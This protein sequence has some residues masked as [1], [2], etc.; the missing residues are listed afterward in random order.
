[1]NRLKRIYLVLIGFLLVILSPQPLKA[2]NG[3]SFT[4]DKGTNISHWLS[5]SQRRGAERSAF[6]TEKDVRYLAGL[7]FD[8]I[9]I[10]VDEEQLWTEDGKKVREAFALLH[11][12][13][14]W[15][16]RAGLNVIVDL[17]ILRSHHFNEGERPLWVDPQ[18]QE[19]FLQC[20]KD[21]S[22]ELKKYPNAL[23]AYELM[24]EPVADDPEDW[25]KL[26][27]KGVEVIRKNE[28]Q[29]TI[30]IGSN[31]WNKPQTFVDLRVPEDDPNFIL[32]FHMYEPMLI[33]HY[34]A[35]W[36][37]TRDFEGEVNYP[38]TIVSED[39]R[40]KL[41]GE[42]AQLVREQ[43]LFYD[44]V[45]IEHHF[46]KAIARAQELN[47]PLHCGEWGVYPTVSD[48]IRFAWYKD[49]L[50]VLHKYDIAWSTWDYKGGFGI[51]RGGEEDKELI[52]ILVG[53]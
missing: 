22:E 28:P 15:S 39:E 41:S 47:L 31:L 21:L 14:Q 3:P 34:K 33:T 10:P 37:K 26:I 30:I 4:M 6:F 36:T 2:Q 32:S 50:E 48:E 5:Q 44:K 25:N 52:Q 17:H 53:K 45:T 20:W 12:G 19:R 27:A 40:N 51:I 7:G 16:R 23:V 49:V 1:M 38:G 8:H 13:I 46:G 18:E 35:S 11:N 42:L 24:N 9:R 43:D 29:R